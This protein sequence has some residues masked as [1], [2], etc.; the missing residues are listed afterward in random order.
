MTS[1][2]EHSDFTK[3]FSRPV[4]QINL[5]ELEC[6]PN[7]PC[8]YTFMDWR[9]RTIDFDSFMFDWNKASEQWTIAWDW[10]HYNIVPAVYEGGSG[11]LASNMPFT[12]STVQNSSTQGADAVE[13]SFDTLW[14]SGVGDP[15]WLSVDLGYIQTINKVILRWEKGF[16]RNYTIDTSNDATA[17][18]TV[19][20]AINGEGGYEEIGFRPVSARFV[21]VH[22]A[23]VIK[24]KSYSLKEFEVHNTNRIAIKMPA[25]YGDKRQ[26]TDGAQEAIGIMAAIYGA[27]LVGIDKSNQVG[28]DYIAMME[29]F[30]H[31]NPD[32]PNRRLAYNSPRKR[33]VHEDWWYDSIPN[34]LLFAI[35]EKYPKERWMAKRLKNIAEALIEMIGCLGKDVP[36]FFHQAFDHDNNCPYDDKWRVPDTGITTALILYWAYRTLNEPRYLEASKRSISYFENIEYN[37]YYEIGMIFGP[38]IV[39][40]LN[41]EHGTSFNIQKHFAWLLSEDSCVRRGWGTIKANWNGYDVYGL[42]GSTTDGGGY[43]FSMGTFATAFLA[44]VV[45]YDH[46][47]AKAVGKFLLNVSNAARFFYPDQMF[48]DNQSHGKRFIKASEHVIAYE[49]L[50]REQ[51]GCSPCATGDP[52]SYGK[53]WG[54]DPDTTDLGVYG[55]GWV[56]LFGAIFSRTN[57]DMILRIDVNALDIYSEKSYPTYLYYNPHTFD[58][59]VQ[60]SLNAAFD[61]FNVLT[62]EYLAKNVFGNQCF[63]IPADDAVLL[64]VV[65]ADSVMSCH[66]S[67]ILIN[68]IVVAYNL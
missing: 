51:N 15:P 49:G 46:R 29:T 44:P 50:R 62:G 32:Y 1:A 23:T 52:G 22:G 16:V 12:I 19:F 47:F 58:K 9:Q 45:K 7:T 57:V 24:G 36:D 33:H 53:N 4:V 41:A 61:L 60:I 14:V 56:G 28:Q 54:L 5:K 48:A 34:L 42:Q 31:T 30:F 13:G 21:R 25:Y 43:A 59:N 37:P 27:S 64:V 65:P 20:T 18:T 63:P 39:A 6:F 11:N 68:N 3:T 40:R 38:Y 55:S 17:W 10:T 66:E 2:I 35:A 8:P 26:L 67:K